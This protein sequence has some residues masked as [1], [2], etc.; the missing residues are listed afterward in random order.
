MFGRTP[1]PISADGRNCT[2]RVEEIGCLKCRDFL[3]LI[4]AMF[5]S[6]SFLKPLHVFGRLAIFAGGLGMAINLYFV[7]VW[8]LGEPVRVR[9]LLVLG[10]ALVAVAI[11]FVLMGLLG[12]MIAAGRPKTD[13]PM[14]FTANFDETAEPGER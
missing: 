11:Q 8:M 5:L 1:H 7:V 6:T 4:A 12:E 9:P 3:D 14:R 2:D 10:L 13:W